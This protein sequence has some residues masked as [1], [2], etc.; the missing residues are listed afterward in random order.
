MGVSLI[1]KRFTKV[2]FGYYFKEDNLFICALFDGLVTSP[3]NNYVFP[4]IC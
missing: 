4:P 1:W 3:Q 2:G